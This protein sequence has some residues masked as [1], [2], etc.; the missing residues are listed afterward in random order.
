MA[1]ALG[2]D[3]VSK[4]GLAAALATATDGDKSK[5]IFVRAD[6]S[7]HYDEFMGLM[8][9][10]RDAGYLKIGLVGLD[11]GKH[12]EVPPGPVQGAAP[13]PGTPEP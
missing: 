6:K 13:P 2:D 8:N 3:P 10:L 12:A 9:T 11:A 5:T 1:G 4:Q 7:V